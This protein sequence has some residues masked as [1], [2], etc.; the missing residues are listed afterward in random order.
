MEALLDLV[1][2]TQKV[3]MNSVPPHQ[4]IDGSFKKKGNGHSEIQM[5]IRYP[6]HKICEKKRKRRKL[7]TEPEES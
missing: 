5:D 4:L 6:I 2:S 3:W 7:S 1:S